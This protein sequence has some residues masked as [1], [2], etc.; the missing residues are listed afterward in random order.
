ML[1][2]TNVNKLEY[3]YL[4]RK[5]QLKGNKSIQ[6]STLYNKVNAIFK[7]WLVIAHDLLEYSYM[8]DVTGNLF[9]LFCSTWRGVLKMF[10]RLFRIKQMK[11][12]KKV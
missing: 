4:K 1:S 9:S 2:G 12:S 10:V 7:L 11:A 3:K 5:E 6:Y 8:N